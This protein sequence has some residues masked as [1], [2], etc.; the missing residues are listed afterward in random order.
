[1]VLSQKKKEGWL[2]ALV[3]LNPFAP[4]SEKMLRRDPEQIPV[5]LELQTIEARFPS[6]LQQLV[7]LGERLR[8]K[9]ELRLFSCDLV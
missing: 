5:A 3:Q 7:L 6:I 1:M 4:L 2:E 9:N 8:V